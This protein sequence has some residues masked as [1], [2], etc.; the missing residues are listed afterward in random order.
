M[1]NVAFFGIGVFRS[2]GC[3]VFVCVQKKS[4]GCP[5]VLVMMGEFYGKV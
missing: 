2:V 5:A 4:P 3:I 1:K